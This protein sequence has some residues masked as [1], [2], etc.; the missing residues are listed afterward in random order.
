M[1]SITLLVGGARS[2]K[3]ALALELGLR[4][5]GPVVF[6]ATAEPIDDELRDRI[7]RHRDERPPWPTVEAPLHLADA[8]LGID[9]D[10]L[11]IVDCL[12]VWLGNLMHHGLPVETHPLI[13]A[14]A[15]RHGPT[16]VVTNEVGMGVHPETELGRRYRDQLGRVNHAMAAAADRTLLL[17]AGRATVLHD[18][19]DLLT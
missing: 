11:A 8:V 4:H 12:T 9:T 2:G 10:A 17:V 13:E 1:G 14:L 6:V 7:R 16:V 19:W 15:A 5:T 18:P 3:S